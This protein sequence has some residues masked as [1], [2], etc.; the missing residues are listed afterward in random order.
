MC[1]LYAKP[2]EA[3][4]SAKCSRTGCDIKSCPPSVRYRA[5]GVV[6]RSVKRGVP[7]GVRPWIT[8]VPNV[9]FQGHVTVSAYKWKP[10]IRRQ[11]IPPSDKSSLRTFIVW[12]VV[13]NEAD[14]VNQFQVLNW[15]MCCHC[16]EQH[17]HHT[18]C[19]VWQRIP[20][21]QGQRKA[22]IAVWRLAKKLNTHT[23]KSICVGEV[24]PVFMWWQSYHFV[25]PVWLSRASNANKHRGFMFV[26]C[27]RQGF[28]LNV[29]RRTG[30]HP[31][32]YLL[33]LSFW[34]PW[35]PQYHHGLYLNIETVC[36]CS[37]FMKTNS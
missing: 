31:K 30:E 13:P 21:F 29:L 11:P 6:S 18:I 14:F 35:L 34:N 15:R 28:D 2:W 12:H 5:L 4:N 25:K 17:V 1:W 37:I 22:E 19:T 23:G 26:Q 36:F 24:Q 16:A 3:T 32:S 7:T 20:L 9:V 10:Y 33:W 8:I 27:V